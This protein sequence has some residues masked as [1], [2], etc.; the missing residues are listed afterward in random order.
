[1]GHHFFP[2]RF[3]SLMLRNTMTD[4]NLT[5]FCPTVDA[6]K[7][8]L[9]KAM[10]ANDFQRVSVPVLPK[11]DRKE[12]WLAEVASEEELGDLH[13]DIKT[14]TEKS[15]APGPIASFLDG[16][17][18]GDGHLPMTEEPIRG[19]PRAW[20][21]GFRIAPDNRPSLLS[22][23]LPDS[24][25]P[26]NASGNLASGSILDTVK[27]NN[28]PLISVFGVSGC[29]KTRAVFELLPQHFENSFAAIDP[30][31]ARE[32]RKRMVKSTAIEQ[33]YALSGL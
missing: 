3:F 24:S 22:V 32:V 30:Y 4:K 23:D 15:F 8:L 18:K 31:F 10:K 27:E 28:H 25:T 21:C 1:M 9:I 26:E 14:I 19:L 6:L 2:L 16:F 29:G 20:R 17:V 7:D 11:K 5:L 13:A 12:I 33:G